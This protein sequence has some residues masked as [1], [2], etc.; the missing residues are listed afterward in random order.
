MEAM[1]DMSTGLVRARDQAGRSVRGNAMAMRL[2]ARGDGVERD[3]AD[4]GW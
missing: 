4:D 3:Q 2:N 1:A